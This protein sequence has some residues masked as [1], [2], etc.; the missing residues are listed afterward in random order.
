[1]KRLA[2]AV[3]VLA[4]ALLVA[5]C[6]DDKDDDTAEDGT[7]PPAATVPV[8]D[9]PTNGEATPIDFG[10]AP[11]GTFAERCQPSDETQFTG[12]EQVIDTSKVYVATI[13]TSKGDILVEL[14]SDVPITT[15]NFVFLACTGFYDGLTFHRVVPNFVIQG[16]DP[17]GTG[18]GGPGYTIP[19]EDDGDHLMER[20]IISMARSTSP[21]SAGS[22]FFI[23]TGQRE[24]IQHLDPDFA[25]FGRVTEGM[26][27]VDRIAQGDAI[28][29]ISIEER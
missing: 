3:T 2:A 1:M 7:T 17:T 20:G 15:N 8:D 14:F 29:T 25:V 18:A 21:D 16:G 19:D 11:M 26:D 10:E 13:S 24:E 28:E 5:A 23:T 27:V 12:P 22:Q 9:E 6:D 4:L